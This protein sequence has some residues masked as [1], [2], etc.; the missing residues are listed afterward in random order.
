MKD[1]F[2]KI[3][4]QCMKGVAIL[5]MVFAH[6]FNNL[7]LCSL[8]TPLVYVGDEPLVHILIYG[9]NPVMFFIFLSGYGLFLSYQQ[10]HGKLI[11]NVRR[12]LKLYIH[13]WIILAIFLPIGC[14]IKGSDVYPESLKLLLENMFGWKSTYNHEAWFLFPYVLLALSSSYLFKWLD[15]AKPLQI[16]LLVFATYLG[17]RVSSRFSGDLRTVSILLYQ[18]DC[19]FTL[20]FPFILGYLAA[21]YFKFSKFRIYPPHISI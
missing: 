1:T 17:E 16:F 11:S 14:I 7:H 3:D 20:L 19:Y 12:C 5:F 9:M 4:T 6:L 18:L 2:S 21:K 13:Y 15:K 10:G 8:S